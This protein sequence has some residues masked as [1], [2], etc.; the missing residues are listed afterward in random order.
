MRPWVHVSPAPPKIRR[1]RKRRRRN[2][3]DRNR[4]GHKDKQNIG[5]PIL[6][7]KSINKPTHS[8]IPDI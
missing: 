5:T 7:G 2:K 8:W 6:I 1:R 4:F 3:K